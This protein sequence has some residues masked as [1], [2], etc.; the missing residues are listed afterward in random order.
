M[1]DVIA[2]P[3]VEHTDLAPAIS[4]LP[5]RD[6]AP[7]AGE[8]VDGFR[9]D[10][11]LS[12][13]RYSRLFKAVDTTDGDRPVVVKFPQPA[14][15]TEK[16]YHLAFVREAW[17]ATRI[18]N[19]WI[20]EVIEVPPEHQTCLYSVMP[21]YEG[22]TL[23]RR[24]GRKPRLTLREGAGIASRIAKAVAALHRA[25]I[26]HRDIKPDNVILESGGGL[27]L[28]DLAWSGCHGWKTSRLPTFRA[29]P[30]TWRRS[31]S[32]ASPATS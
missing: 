18:H 14:V 11:V 17:V 22:E 13:G 12:D 27:R 7:K 16:T 24:L 4:A 31:C 28:I 10:G 6:P 25:G 26:V 20:G 19:P 3:A 5:I 2:L 9:L 23:E 1:I 21:F 30:A 29:R 8:T 32:P 15:A